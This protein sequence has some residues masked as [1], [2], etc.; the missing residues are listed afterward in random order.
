MTKIYEDFK[1]L[2]YQAYRVL[3]ENTLSNHSAFKDAKLL[4]TVTFQISYTMA[5]EFQAM[6]REFNLGL[7][8][9]KTLNAIILNANYYRIKTMLQD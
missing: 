8:N 5:S 2:K 4:L 9:F 6:Y 7:E 1:F 3:S